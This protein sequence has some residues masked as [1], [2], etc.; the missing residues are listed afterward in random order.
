MNKSKF[1][2]KSLAM[3]LALM[4]VLAMIPLSASAAE[5]PAVT[6]VTVNGVTATGSDTSLSA[7]ITET[8]APVVVT[9]EIA[10]DAGDVAYYGDATLKDTNEAE[11]VGEVWQFTLSEGDQ[12]DKAFTFDVLDKASKQPVETYT[13]TYTTV[14]ADG[15][16]SV[17][18]VYLDGQ[19]GCWNNTDTRGEI[20]YTVVA[21]YN[22]TLDNS[23]YVEVTPNGA[24]ASVTPN[25]GTVGSAYKV[26]V[27]A[28]DSRVE[29][30]VTAANGNTENYTVTVVKPIPFATFSVEG[31]R[32]EAR[33]ERVTEEPITWEVAP[34]SGSKSNP[35]VE[36]YLP[37]KY[38][39]TKFTATFT[40]N[41]SVKVYATEFENN[42]AGDPVELISGNTYDWSKL[43]TET[44]KDG[45]DVIIPITVKYS[46][47]KEEPWT[48]AL[49]VCTNT[50]KEE[51][52]TIPAIKGVIAK[53]YVATIDGTTITL[54]LP[55][56][57]RDNCDDLQLKISEDTVVNVVDTDKVVY[58]AKGAKGDGFVKVKGNTENPF[59]STFFQKD[60]Y[61]LRVTAAIKEF[62][63]NAPAV[64][65]YTLNI[66]TA[67]VEKPQ[68]NSLT[69]KSEKTGE[70][71]EGRIDHEAGRVYFEGENAIPYRYKKVKAMADDEWQLFWSVPSGTTL[72]WNANSEA[73]S[74]TIVA[75]SG[76]E[77]NKDMQY[78][79]QDG[80]F[81]NTEANAYIV[82]ANDT[83]SRAYKVVFT[84]AE[85][86]K[87]ADLG[88][89]QLAWN[90]VTKFD[91]LNTQNTV[92]AIVNN[93]NTIT[94]TIRY[95]DW[96]KFN[97]WD[98]DTNNGTGND[99]CG[100]A[101][102]TTLP[103][104]AELYWVTSN[105][106]LYEV[107]TLNEENPTIQS[108]LASVN[109]AYPYGTTWNLTTKQ[110][111]KAVETLTLI[112][113]SEALAE[114]IGDADR[115][116]FN[117]DNTGKSITLEK[118]ENKAD[119]AGL[120]QKY[121]LTLTQAEP[122]IGNKLTSLSVYDNYTGTK[123]DGVLVGNTFTVTLPYYF[124]D[125]SRW[126]VDNLY[127]DY[128]PYQGGQTVYAESN[129]T[130]SGSDKVELNYLVKKEDGS[131][132]TDA[133]VK[134]QWNAAKDNTTNAFKVFED[135][136][137]TDSTKK[138]AWIGYTEYGSNN[139]VVK[140]YQLRVKAE[141]P[142][143]KENVYDV[144]IKVADA[145]GG[146][147]LNSVSYGNSTATPNSDNEVTLNVPFSTE[148]TSM[149]LDFNVS[150]NAYVVEGGPE[151]IGTGNDR[152][153]IVDEGETFN[154]LTTRTFTV[155]SENHAARETYT[156]TVVPSETFSDVTTDQWY[157][158]E[159]M[160]AAN[161]GWINGVGNG[162][163]D[164][165]GTMK[166]GDFAVIIARIMN[167][168][169]ENYTKSAFPDVD[170]DLYYS[171]A[172]A[173][174][175][176]Q[177]IIDGDNNGNFNAEDPITREEMA[178]ILCQ[179]KQLKVTIPEKTYADDA[180]IAQWAKGYVYACQEAGIMEGSGDNFNPRD[181]ATRAEG[182]AVL[183]RAFA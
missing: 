35:Q 63:E 164:P 16:A 85:A 146:A 101:F 94:A 64:Q 54:T 62:D 65:D 14:P 93:D 75:L 121:E 142:D 37:Y 107:D 109:K 115:N 97:A 132:D 95:K 1:L 105:G 31:E 169:P 76:T 116:T 179:A 48:L 127:L 156:I 32:H 108:Y 44:A 25:N 17:K 183:V 34:S 122:G 123:V 42:V 165:N 149:A 46:D 160:T 33:I 98:D 114:D 79:P 182:A 133:S 87:N 145:E 88:K 150:E 59:P 41:Y 26:P 144:V 113:V 18:S 151:N 57:V 172:I 80:R 38:G 29:F 19:Y 162:R 166:R 58:R 153:N 47:G 134:L 40:T 118:L 154:F 20:H 30:T 36:A 53:N 49:D 177:N 141:N 117:S 9:V 157:Y 163:F 22:Y 148:V 91:E 104:G 135:N 3:L 83:S 125:S 51:R 152:K 147:V 167:Y 4:L 66:V 176:E 67:K 131:V 112:V 136:D 73:P 70:T 15:D 50:S 28:Y 96:E 170:S 161:M 7:T 140:D 86:S 139:E 119:Y 102:V 24:G 74:D 90:K 5:G 106:S 21:P 128:A 12:A 72:T 180:E 159:V 173:F 137:S 55:Q 23:T 130:S 84:S 13:V 82:V 120:Y 39:S 100:A 81:D 92:D 111:D 10:D 45:E 77:V 129:K 43:K 99:Q 103:A 178:K 71:L 69:L 2:K 61:T 11:K 68:L 110:H 60:S 168:D 158:D 6:E 181:N 171:A 155:V 89:V 8:S 56:S 124:T 78:L 175:K 27:T 174:C 126:S 138:S 143:T 52:D